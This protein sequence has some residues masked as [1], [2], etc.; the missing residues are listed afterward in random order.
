MRAI[1]GLFTT[2]CLTTA[3]FA[4]EPI[5]TTDGEASGQSLQ[6]T[7]LKVSNGT[8]MLRFTVANDS[9]TD[10]SNDSFTDTNV[11][12][13]DYHSV[14]GVYLLDTANKKKYLVVY[15]TENHCV[16][17]RGIDYVRS[18]KSLNFWAKFPAPPDN[19]T[20]IGIVVPHFVPMDDVPLSR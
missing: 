19:V 1:I 6:V 10:V 5:A 17:S 11:S 9:T 2:L 12:G 14:S 13:P 8:V 18:K 3:A 7:Q 4:A 20:T 15:D 16:C